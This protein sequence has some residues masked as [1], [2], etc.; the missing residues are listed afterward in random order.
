MKM[1]YL[2]T[3]YATFASISVAQAASFMVTQKFVEGVSSSKSFFADAQINNPL[4]EALREKFSSLGN[5]QKE[6]AVQLVPVASSSQ[7][8]RGSGQ[9]R[10]RGKGRPSLFMRSPM[11]F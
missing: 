8:R 9:G 3:A 4:C 6:P 5:N 10:G 7:K 11:S 2:I 1:M